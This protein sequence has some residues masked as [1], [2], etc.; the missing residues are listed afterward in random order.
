MDTYYK[1]ELVS[2]LRGFY[3][4]SIIFSLSEHNFFKNFLENRGI[5]KNNKILKNHNI[6]FLINYLLDINYLI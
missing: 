6:K 5:S 3:L 2:H 4:S 1:K